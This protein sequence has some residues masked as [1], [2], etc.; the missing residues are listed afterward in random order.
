MKRTISIVI[1]LICLFSIGTFQSFA[2][3]DNLIYTT[4]EGKNIYYCLDENLNPYYIVNGE[5]MYITLPLEHLKVTDKQIIAELNQSMNKE[6]AKST[7]TSYYDISTGGTSTDSPHYTRSVSFENSTSFITPVLK[8]NI[9]HNTMRVKAS[10]IVK[11][12]IFAGKKFDLT[13]Y[14]Y[15]SIDDA[16]YT[17]SHTGVHLES[18]FAFYHLPSTFNFGKVKVEKNSAIKTFDLDVWTSVLH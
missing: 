5:K 12:H 8:L 1:T 11:Q 2:L 4:N 9:S 14:Y 7:P 15:D 13:Y 18:T 16:W 6:S 17:Q 10:N 3:N